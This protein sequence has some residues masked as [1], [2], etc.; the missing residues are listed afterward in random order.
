MIGAPAVGAGN[1]QIFGDVAENAAAAP[2]Q[3]DRYTREKQGRFAEKV[4]KLN[5]A[6]LQEKFLPV[7]QEFLDVEGSPGGDVSPGLAVLSLL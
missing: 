5:E 7:L 1:L 4:Q 3:E 2:R 6:R